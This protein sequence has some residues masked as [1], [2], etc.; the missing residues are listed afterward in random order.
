MIGHKLTK[1]LYSDT[2]W[3]FTKLYPELTPKEREHKITEK[4]GAVFL[5]GIGGKLTN[6]EPHDF[7]APDYDDWTTLDDNGKA[8]LNADLLVWD[9]TRSM[10]LEIS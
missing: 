7:I 6:D 8:G 4:H 3:R 5:I 9:Y 2:F 1:L 10:S